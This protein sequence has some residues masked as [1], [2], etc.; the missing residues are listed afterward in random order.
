MAKYSFKTI[1][2]AEKQHTQWAQV[3][4]SQVQTFLVQNFPEPYKS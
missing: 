1:D 2:L 3:D 4:L